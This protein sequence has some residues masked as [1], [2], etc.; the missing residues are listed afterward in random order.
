MVE[1]D[2]D[3]VGPLTVAAYEASDA[4]V[5]ESYRAY[6]LDARERSGDGLVLVA[7]DDDGRVV[8]SV[9][10]AEPGDAA[11]E[12]RRP[13]PGDASFRMLAVAPEAQGTG[14]GKALVDA[15][16][17]RARGRGRRRLVITTMPTMTTAHAMYAGLGFVRRPDL[18]VTF[19]SG[20][21]MVLHLDLTDDAADRFPP[22]GP[23]PDEPPWY[24]DVW[25]P[26]P[27]D[28]SH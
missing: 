2:H 13:C 15:C 25:V 10:Y 20:V 28:G 3:V 19:P 12:S 23:V 6:L 5:G 9:V 8:G 16:L 22:P 14:A 21:G 4:F 11:W 17:T 1:A 18:D 26:D 24:E 27:H 7:V